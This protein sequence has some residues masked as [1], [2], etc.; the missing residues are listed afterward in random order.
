VRI[1]H[2]LP[3]LS[4][5]GMETLVIQLAQDAVGRGDEVAVASGPGLWIPKVAT[6]GA[7]YVAMPATSRSSAVGM[8][9]AAARLAGCVR[10]MR[11][12][13][14]HS[15]NVRATA[16]ARLALSAGRH[17][18]VLMPTLHGVHPADY[19]SAGRV[20]RRMAPRVIA[21]APAVGR[22]L[23]SAGFPSTRID[24]IANGA[25]LQPASARRQEELRQRLGL[26]RRPLV[27]GIGRLVEQKG[28]PV[29]IA[30]AS[31]LDGPSFVV[32]GDGPLRPEL[33]DLSA[34]CGGRVRFLGLV[35]DIAALVGVSACVVFTSHWEG[36]PLA[37]LEALSLGAPA[38]AT[39]VDGVT[40]LVPPDAALFV[41]PGSPAAVSAAISRILTNAQLADSLRQ[42]ARTASLAWRPERMLLQY[43][44]AYRAAEAGDVHWV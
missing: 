13:V 9:A 2:V 11:P 16:L 30:A 23:E 17:R 44:N 21:C 12:H 25:V 31:Q 1:L 41:P 27:L 3:Q 29:L 43:S 32:A 10:V 20:L 34:R 14:V 22:S 38:V 15:H 35:D 28:W 37:L 24:V 18:A 5:G 6:V 4:P 39:A 19:A 42:R 40:D 33:A 26:G 8:A 36:L 7:R